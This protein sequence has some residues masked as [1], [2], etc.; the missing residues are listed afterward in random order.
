MNKKILGFQIATTLAT[1]ALVVSPAFAVSATI[2]LT[3]KQ[4]RGDSA[5]EKRIQSLTDLETRINDFKHVSDSDKASLDAS[6]KAQLDAMTTLKTK[7]DNDTDKKTL[8]DDVKSITQNYRIFMVVEP[9]ARIT[10]AA[11]RA[12]ELGT[13]F[14]TLSA[15]LQVKITAANTAGN[16]VTSLNANLT[17]MNAKVTDATNQANA[18]IALVAHL[19]PDNGNAT[20]ATSNKTALMNARADLKKAND[21]LKA[22]R[23]DVKSI[24]QVLKGFNIS[25]NS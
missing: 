12:L 14:T 1:L 4:D 3:A 23:V 2:N 8:K 21:D 7:I 25:T 15:K 19:V 11:D 13:S 10:A 22:A 24:V 6:I 9:Q 20:V 16:N 18:A 17:D 5:T